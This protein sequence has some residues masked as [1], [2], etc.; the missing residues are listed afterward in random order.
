[1]V[2][3]ETVFKHHPE[4]LRLRIY[5]KGQTAVPRPSGR[6]REARREKAGKEKDQ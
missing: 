3:Y 4:V 6:K 2:L 5:E 1:L